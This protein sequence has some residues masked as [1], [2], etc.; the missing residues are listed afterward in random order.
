MTSK[1]MRLNNLKLKLVHGVR[2][3]LGQLAVNLG[4]ASHQAR[5]M[6][7]DEKDPAHKAVLESSS[8]AF[9]QV[10]ESV[11][12]YSQAVEKLLKTLQEWSQDID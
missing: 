3:Q 2:P 6:A 9:K 5:Q 12:R 10:S 4:D 7:K 8:K 11:E 1:K